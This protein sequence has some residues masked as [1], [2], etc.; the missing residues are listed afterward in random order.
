N[1]QHRPTKATATWIQLVNEFGLGEVRGHHIYFSRQDYKAWREILAADCGFDPTQTVL[2]GD[3]TAV[4][5]LTPNEKWSTESMWARRVSTTVIG[6]DLVTTT[7]RCEIIPGVDYGVDVN[8]LRPAD[9]DAVLVI[10][11]SEAF[12]YAHLF[13]TPDLGHLLV[14]YRGH[15]YSA[16]TVMTFLEN[17]TDMPVIGFTDPDPAGAGLLKGHK[18]LTH[19]L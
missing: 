18:L 4:S 15:D 13:H 14:L 7:G 11:N 6:G 9:Y 5:K 8:T 12:F 19:A 2:S 17:S 16:R 3:R 10:E 1:N